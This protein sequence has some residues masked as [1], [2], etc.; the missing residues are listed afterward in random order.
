M[1]EHDDDGSAVTFPPL[2]PPPPPQPA[3][4]S[5]GAAV[6]PTSAASENL[7][8]TLPP[9]SPTSTMPRP[10]RA[11]RGGVVKYRGNEGVI[12]TSTRLQWLCQAE[13][14]ELVDAPDSKS[15]GGNL[16]WVR[17][18]PS[19][20]QERLLRLSRRAAARTATTLAREHRGKEA[21]GRR[22]R[23]GRPR[24]PSR[25]QFGLCERASGRLYDAGLPGRPRRRLRPRHDSGRG[26]P[27]HAARR[28]GR[29]QGCQDST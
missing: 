2:P 9:W 29:V 18:P 8:D 25:R 16:V 23:A 22:S 10:Q 14:A 11:R 19:A 27:D 3:A 4:R 28:D 26:R 17:V 6:T 24:R 15:G 21:R 20:L 13:V 7:L 5:A 12:S 1:S